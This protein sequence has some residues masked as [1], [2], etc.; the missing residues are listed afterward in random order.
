MRERVRV[1]TCV[2]LSRSSLT[3]PARPDVPSEARPF[4][5]GDEKWM[6]VGA[7]RVGLHTANG[8]VSLSL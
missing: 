1:L 7:L 2:Q 4:L 5:F 8:L 3:S 6:Q